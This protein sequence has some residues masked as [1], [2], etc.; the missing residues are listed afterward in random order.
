F[1]RPEGAPGGE[2][3]GLRRFAAGWTV[4]GLQAGAGGATLNPVPRQPP[5]LRERKASSGLDAE[6][7]GDAA[8]EIT[9]HD[10]TVRKS[11]CERV[12]QRGHAGG[13]AGEVERGHV[14][15]LASRGTYRRMGDGDEARQHAVELDEVIA[16]AFHR[17]PGL[18]RAE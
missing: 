1:R 12:A 10:P 2:E 4:G 11:F 8:E 6:T 5:G 17:E 18:D 9:D 7:R 13:S 14:R 15:R 16:G 3:A